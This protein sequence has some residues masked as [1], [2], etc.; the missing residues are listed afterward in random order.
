MR[1]DLTIAFG[2]SGQN[3]ADGGA[4]LGRS[5][6]ALDGFARNDIGTH[7]NVS[8]EFQLAPAP[9]PASAHAPHL[10]VPSSASGLVGT[11]PST[12][13]SPS[14]GASPTPG[15]SAH[16]PPGSGGSAQHEEAM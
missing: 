4:S 12:G 15:Q 8:S 7:S 9:G 6:S 11:S 3:G 14:P 16:S 5:R 10:T 13:A 1:P 2:V